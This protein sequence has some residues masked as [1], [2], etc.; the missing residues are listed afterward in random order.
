MAIG[1]SLDN[2]S[3]TQ[4]ILNATLLK[5]GSGDFALRVSGGDASGGGSSAGTVSGGGL[6]SYVATPSGTNGDATVA[7]TAA[8][9]ITISAGI[10]S[11]P[12]SFIKENIVSITQIPNA[13]GADIQD[14][15]FTDKADFS[16]TGSVITVEG[17]S[18]AATDTF[19]VDFQ[20][21]P[22]NTD[23]TNQANRTTEINGP[24]TNYGDLDLVDT[25]DVAATTHYYPAS[26]GF[27]MDGYK[28]FS[29]SGKLIDA[30]G[31]LTVTLEVSND[32][33]P[34]TAD[35]VQVYGYDD[36]NNTTVNTW[37]V[38]NGT[39]L[40]ANSFSNM[41][42]KHVRLVLVASGATSTEILKGKRK[43]L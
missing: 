42:Y 25:T 37:T 8:T 38:T 17:A 1:P 12:A 20:F 2:L 23:E 3:T 35:W 28:D 33:D 26:T 9:T 14:I 30:D 6:S 7:Y 5:D 41:N 11:F 36:Y 34:A 40:L 19:V 21:L 13:G 24:Q 4:D 27:S 16:V 22:K 39:L 43:A 15:I 32:E 31:T 10:A 18:F 29:F